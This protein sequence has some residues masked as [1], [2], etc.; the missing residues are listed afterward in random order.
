[1]QDQKLDISLVLGGSQEY[2]SS[3]SVQDNI[4]LALSK[5]LDVP[6]KQVVFTSLS[7]VSSSRRQQGSTRLVFT[8]TTDTF[9]SQKI[10]ARNDLLPAINTMLVKMSLPTAISMEAS[11]VQGNQG[12]GDS[13]QAVNVGLVVGCVVGGLAF[14]GLVAGVVYWRLFPVRSQRVYH[15]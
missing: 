5:V 4:S 13:G 10:L 1:V 2:F 9:G 3:K 12:Q 15:E 7:P 8:V 6:L 14:V 11:P